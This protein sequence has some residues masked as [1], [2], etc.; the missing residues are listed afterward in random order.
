M[1]AT[2]DTPR[3]RRA[4]SQGSGREVFLL[5][6]L[7]IFAGALG[8]ILHLVLEVPPEQAALA[9]LCCLSALLAIYALA[10][11]SASVTALNAEIAGLKGEI[12]ALRQRA[13]S[14]TEIGHREVFAGF[15]APGSAGIRS[16]ATQAFHA[17]RPPAEPRISQSP[18][19]PRAAGEDAG[20]ALSTR[21]GR[22]VAPVALSEADHSAQ[23]D[24]ASAS[25]PGVP[26]LTGANAADVPSSGA[27]TALPAPRA[28]EATH[29]T[30][31]AATSSID[32]RPEPA[33]MA[34]YWSLR[35]GSHREPSASVPADLRPAAVVV[36]REP[37]HPA[38]SS[39]TLQPAGSHRPAPLT[40][41]P[42][43]M[44]TV[45]DGAPRSMPRPE[46][47]EWPRAEPRVPTAPL[48]LDTMQAI[49]EQLSGQMSQAPPAAAASAAD[50]IAGASSLPVSD[51]E[52][53]RAGAAIAAPPASNRVPE[54]APLR[55]D[56]DPAPLA[57]APYG[58]IALIAEAVEAR[59]MDVCLEPIL[60]LA[61]RK[62]RHFELSL[63]LIA[64]DGE[65]FAEDAYAQ[66]AAGTGLLARIDAAKLE[67]AV[68]VLERLR[69]RGSRA[70]LFSSI[71]AESLADDNF[72][73]AFADILAD[74]E[75]LGTRL[76]LTFAQAEARNFR[77]AHWRVIADMRAIGLKF[78]LAEVTDLDMDFAHLKAQGFDFVK[79]DA[80]VF[81]EGLP[82]AAGLIPS[83]D[84]C[85]HLAEQGLGLI[86]GGIVAE[87]DLA[88]ILGFGV[89]LGQG[90]LF[91]GPRSVE[92]ERERRAA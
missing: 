47:G 87:K 44:S 12:A 31:P 26:P 53:A 78:T 2:S 17:A 34:G 75:S 11:R 58:H 81:L 49:I 69:T 89:L 38:L 28:P 45:D 61:D 90:T 29:A 21:E 86:V 36:M 50:R 79:L 83:E 73:S 1:N 67:R 33:T 56:G 63:R 25:A 62:A 20:P 10:H 72:A 74:E 54:P 5:A 43:T 65:E 55:E 35:P 57:A 77:E 85:R 39:R 13:V 82:T 88:R 32:G 42:A 48:D 16:D 46:H 59:R 52:A 24:P 41:F 30:A 51:A 14:A 60:G 76:V 27:A 68:E 18:E 3:S 19:R 15:A 71:A 40:P 9:A 22:L 84:I 7:A 91:G 8:A 23:T 4:P 80:Q 70:A 6:C 64:A 92:V 66:V 37:P